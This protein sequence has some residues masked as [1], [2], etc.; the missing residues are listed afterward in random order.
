MENLP[1][2]KGQVLDRIRPSQA[3]IKKMAEIV[4]K[5]EKK[6]EKHLP[7][8]VKIFLSGSIAKQTFLRGEGDIDMFLLF[9]KSFD[10][11]MM[12]K[13]VMDI[14]KKEFKDY[15]IAY[16]EHPY[17]R[18]FI[19]EVKA[20]IVPAY[21]IRHIKHMGTAVDR[22]K[23]HVS[24]VKKYIKDKREDV[25]VLKKLLK[26][27][28]IYGADIKTKGIS[29]YL[30]ELIIIKY[31]GFENA[32]EEIS[33]WNIGEIVEISKKWKKEEDLRNKFKGDPLI[34]I[35]P[36]DRNRNV[37]SA[38][39]AENLS[40]LILI[41]RAFKKKESI[42]FFF[43]KEKRPKFMPELIEVSFKSPDV[44]DETKYGELNRF[45]SKIGSQLEARGYDLISVHSF[46]D[47]KK[48]GCILG[49]LEPKI[50]QK[51]R[52]EGPP[53]GMATAVSGFISKGGSFFIT[54]KIFKVCKRSSTEIIRNM[55]EII[56]VVKGPKHFELRTM[57]ISYSKKGSK[58]YKMA[59]RRRALDEFIL[60]LQ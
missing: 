12:G 19:D 8:D 24:F 6:I 25:L 1:K 38:I 3:E 37:A 36:T 58:S 31:S 5:I 22:T 13:L 27:F 39:S 7:V 9:P 2:L 46:D 52:K 32:I 28:G 33:K 10:K 4:K 30:T 57:R 20:D 59:E 43:M 17:A 47:K 45:G 51:Y 23:F 18:I 35:D 26:N 42:S 41:A 29:G 21:N 54:D 44:I 50:Q 53:L 14:V 40:R 49:V 11:E 56:N 60:S 16:A 15:E 34:F 48:A 55:K